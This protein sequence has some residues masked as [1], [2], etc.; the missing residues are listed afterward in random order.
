MIL[1]L[2]K[3]LM[4]VQDFIVFGMIEYAWQLE[5]FASPLLA[6]FKATI[7][8][9]PQAGTLKSL[10]PGD[11]LYI[12]GHGSRTGASA[13]PP[14]WEGGPPEIPWRELGKIIGKQAK[15]GPAVVH[16]LA[17]SAAVGWPGPETGLHLVAQ[18]LRDE[19][20]GGIKVR[21]Y[22]GP[23]V[24]NIVTFDPR[25]IQVPTGG[26][27]AMTPL[28]D[29]QNSVKHKTIPDEKFKSWRS[30]HPKA[31]VHQV[32]LAAT[33]ECWDF[34]VKFTEEFEK[35][36]YFYGPTTAGAQLREVAS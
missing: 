30:S 5:A 4:K 27:D 16:I 36:G 15:K 24:T 35:K 23:T 2:S 28:F 14:P 7:I 19:A 6:D 26:D 3:D 9:L 11:T 10:G 33:A 18:G 17:C 22:A 13:D 25:V 1:A 34:Y 21:G 32:A 8:D 29:T 12:V 31:S 20:R